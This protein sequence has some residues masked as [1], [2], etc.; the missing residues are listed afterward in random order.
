MVRGPPLRR[1]RHGPLGRVGLQLSLWYGHWTS[2]CVKCEPVRRWG[3]VYSHWAEFHQYAWDHED[4]TLSNGQG[5]RLRWWHHQRRRMVLIA[6]SGRRARVEPGKFL[7]MQFRNLARL[8]LHWA[9]YYGS[10]ARNGLWQNS[11]GESD[12][13]TV[14]AES[15]HFSLF[16]ETVSSNIKHTSRYLNVIKPLHKVA[17]LHGGLRDN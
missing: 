9:W 2:L 7:V 5:C 3:R 17:D 6:R 14:H 16:L 1:L 15:R 4:T 10:N 8:W 12:Q 11:A 13:Y